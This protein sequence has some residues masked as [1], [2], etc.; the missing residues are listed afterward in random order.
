MFFGLN[1]KQKLL[2]YRVI[3]LVFTLKSRLLYP[4]ACSH[5]FV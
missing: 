5:W 4:Y 2:I 1:N 3:C